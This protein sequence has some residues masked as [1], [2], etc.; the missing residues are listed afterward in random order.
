MPFKPGNTEG[1]KGKKAKPYADALRIAIMA[2]DGDSTKLRRIAE[3]HV[4]LAMAGDMAAIN[5]AADRLDG[6][7]P[8][9]IVG[10][11]DHPGVK[12]EAVQRTIVDPRPV[13]HTDSSGLPAPTDNEPV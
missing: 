5:A 11:D 7:V 3:K 10:D 8:Q 2:A 13:G 1:A 6:K 12:L 4:A 9:A